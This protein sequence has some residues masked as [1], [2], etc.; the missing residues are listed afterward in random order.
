MSILDKIFGR[1]SGGQKPETSPSDKFAVFYYVRCAKCGEVIRVRLDRRNDFE[2]QFDEKGHDEVAGYRVYKEVMGSG[3]CFKMMA[4]ELKFDRDY[5][6]REKSVRGG[7][8]V[9]RQDYEQSRGTP[10]A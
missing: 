1:Q 6:E 8:F 4:L 3:N 9:T 2:Q 7:E 5:R 10:T